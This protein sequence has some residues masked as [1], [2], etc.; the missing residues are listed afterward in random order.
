MYI[1][2]PARQT[3]LAIA[4]A[5]PADP[6]TVEKVLRSER[7][8]VAV[9]DRVHRAIVDLGLAHLLAQPLHDPDTSEDLER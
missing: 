2:R 6:R 9:R 7:T 1:P 3:V 5:A 4:V 8:Q